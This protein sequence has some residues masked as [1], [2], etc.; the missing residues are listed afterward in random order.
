MPDETSVIDYMNEQETEFAD[1]TGFRDYEVKAK[2]VRQQT[3]GELMAQVEKLKNDKRFTKGKVL[4]ESS[5]R[6]EINDMIV[7]LMSY[8][9]S[10]N[11]LG[12]RKKTDHNLVRE[13]VNA[14][15]QIFTAMKNGDASD[16]ITKAELAAR[17]IVENLKLVE[18]TAYESIRTS[19]I[20]CEL[21]G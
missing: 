17:Q 4:D 3:Y 8:G 14:A 5:V 20:I 9:E 13:G 10:Y 21:R 1:L 16:V 12:V 7:T 18:D 11:S 6:E 15:K 2:Q 19:E